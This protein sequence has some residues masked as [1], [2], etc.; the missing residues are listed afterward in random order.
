MASTTH[1]HPDPAAPTHS[2]SFL[3]SLGILCCLPVLVIA[4]VL[5]AAGG[6]RPGLIVP[7]LVAGAV[8]G[9]LT[10]ITVGDARR[11]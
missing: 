10:F 2:R 8:I 7:A 11:G 1:I 9:L 6:T 4:I 3:Q 5:V